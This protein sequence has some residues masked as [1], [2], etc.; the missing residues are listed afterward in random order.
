VQPFWPTCVALLCVI[1]L[2]GGAFF[3]CAGLLRIGEVHEI[4]RAVRRRLERAR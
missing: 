4:V 1:A 2:S 3:L